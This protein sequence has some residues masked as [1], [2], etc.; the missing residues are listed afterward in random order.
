MGFG[1]YP[2]PAQAGAQFVVAGMRKIGSP[3]A[4]GRVFPIMG[5]LPEGMVSLNQTLALA[6][7]SSHK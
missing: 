3:P 7:L 2:S 1:S 4:R 5:G 6:H